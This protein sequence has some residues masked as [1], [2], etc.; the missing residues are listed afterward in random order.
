MA[1]FAILASVGLGFATPGERPFSGLTNDGVLSQADIQTVV[2]T[3]VSRGSPIDVLTGGCESGQPVFDLYKRIG[4]DDCTAIMARIAG[5]SDMTPQD[6]ATFII[7]RV[8][9]AQVIASRQPGAIPE[10]ASPPTLG[11][12][13]WVSVICSNYEGFYTKMS[14]DPDLLAGQP[15]ALRTAV[16][17]L[18]KEKCA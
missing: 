17:E 9:L 2:S 7:G 10:G 14:T 4:G 15:A 12:D 6:V 16:H 13:V 18:I 11:E 8:L 3:I 5:D 1:A